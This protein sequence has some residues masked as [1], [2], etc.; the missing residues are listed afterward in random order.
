ME[1]S[2]LCLYSFVNPMSPK[3][4]FLSVEN[5]N[6]IMQNIPREKYTDIVSEVKKI[7]AAFFLEF[8]SNWLRL[9]TLCENITLFLVLWSDAW[10]HVS[11]Q[12]DYYF[13]HAIWIKQSCKKKNR[14]DNVQ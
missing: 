10:S 5:I 4:Y 8:Y 2:V 13:A 12:L 11:R 3:T 1:Q 6:I 9:I 14:K 7:L